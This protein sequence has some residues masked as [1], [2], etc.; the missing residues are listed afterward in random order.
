MQF[1]V[2]HSKQTTA[3]INRV[4]EYE[5]PAAVG[6][7]GQIDQADASRI[8]GRLD[9]NYGHVGLAYASYLGSNH[10]AV[11][12]EVEGFYKS[13]GNELNTSNEERYWRVMVCCLLKGAEYSN[14]LK[15]TNI[16]EQALK[17]FLIKVVGDLRL[18]K[19]NTSVDLEK[20]I[21]VSE[22]VTRF[23]ADQS[24]RHMIVTDKINRA[25]GVPAP[26]SIKVKT[27]VTRLENITVHVATDDKIVRIS[28][29]DLE[30]WL[31]RNGYSSAAVIQ[32]VMDRYSAASIQSRMASGTSKAGHGKQRMIEIDYAKNPD[33]DPEM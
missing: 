9:D 2:Q 6:N 10:A 33:L 20:A 24:A 32:A 28:R 26:N 19:N 8:L 13:I 30:E 3:G 7:T 25:V 29:P 18:E 12:K 4:F 27:D 31:R 14:K 23:I 15:F 22:I 16:D 21:N 5:V 11:S 17:D 1:V